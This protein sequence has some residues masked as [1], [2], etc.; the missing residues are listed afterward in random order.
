MIDLNSFTLE[1]LAKDNYLTAYSIKLLENEL[2]LHIE[3]M[4]D[5]VELEHNDFNKMQII[6]LST[7]IQDIKKAIGILTMLKTNQ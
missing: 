3:E 7:L 4:D 2:T 5:F 1:S 6:K